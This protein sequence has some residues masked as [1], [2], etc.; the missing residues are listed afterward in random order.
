[1]ADTLPDDLAGG[2]VDTCSCL[3]DENDFGI[4]DHGHSTA[5]LALVTA[6]K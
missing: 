5:K 4:T 6:G 2:R 1:M 3:V